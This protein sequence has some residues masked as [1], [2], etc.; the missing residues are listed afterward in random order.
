MYGVN[1][2][3]IMKEDVER[4]S[5]SDVKKKRQMQTISNF[6]GV[7]EIIILSSSFRNEYYLYVDEASFSHGEFLRYL[8]EE[9]DKSLQ[10]I[11]LETYSKFNE[12]VLRHLF[13]VTNCY[14]YDKNGSLSDCLAAVE[15]ALEVSNALNTSGIILMR[16]FNRALY[17]A[18]QLVTQDN[19]K[20]LNDSTIAKYIYLLKENLKDLEKK[21]II[22]SGDTHEIYYL[23]KILLLAGVQSVTVLQEEEEKT[24]RQLAIIN[25]LLSKS[26]RTKIYNGN[27]KSFYYRLSKADAVILDTAEINILAQEIQEEISVVRQTKKIQ[28]LIDLSGISHEDILDQD[29][30]IRF[31]DGTAPLS[32]I[33]EDKKNVRLWIDEYLT[34]QVEQFMQYFEMEQ[35]NVEKEVLN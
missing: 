19:F 7:E 32:F 26:S 20:P 4:Y 5:L 17:L 2:E 12:D 21:N 3:T 34:D 27:N 10:E 24:K 8:A 30:D 35:L 1:R 15:K 11:I 9:T 16:L 31:I 22:I 29:L 33:E 18:Y 25:P 14:F 13:E 6:D 28:Y 23:I